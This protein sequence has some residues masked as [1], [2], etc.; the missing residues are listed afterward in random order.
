MC[1]G[2]PL[3]QATRS[4]VAQGMYVVLNNSFSGSCP[5]QGRAPKILVFDS[6]LGGLTVLA[7]LVKARPD[8]GF[9]YVADDA[10]F[11]YGPLSQDEL[12]AR[13]MHVLS[14][15]IAVHQPDCVVI[16]CNTASTVVL[17]MLRGRFSV[18]FVGT[19][20]AIKP[21]AALSRSRIMAVLATPGTVAR[22]YT[23]GLIR[24]FAGD[25]R[26]VL[27]GSPRLA[28]EAEALLRAK[29]VRDDVIA[30]EIAPCFVEED[31]QRT[32]VIA[33]SCTHYPLLIA[34][35]QRL[36]PWPV[37]FID[38]APAIA[39]RVVQVLGAAVEDAPRLQGMAV[40]TGRS[41]VPDALRLRLA[42][43]GLAT[44][45]TIDMPMKTHAHDNDLPIR[46]ICP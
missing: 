26:V 15:Q 9:I 7:E 33:L 22:D 28:G 36:A 31:G 11:P 10:G 43:S 6:G 13:V 24:E 39:R 1:I 42:A 19:V 12:C 38:P 32:D 44:A 16:A 27:V 25:C 3:G 8:A 35:L 45:E 29:P 18:P 5:G 37:S 23:H 20:P 21:A 40:F 46:M 2:M 4:K 30:A 17:P 41:A 34:Q 14:H